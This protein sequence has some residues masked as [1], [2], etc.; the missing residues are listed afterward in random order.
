VRTLA[1]RS[2]QAA[3]EIKQLIS[4]SV[5][6]VES[7]S[8]LVREAGVTMDDI[9][10]SVQRVSQVIGEITAATSEQS[11]GLG[12]INQAVVQLDRMTQQNAALVEQSSAAAESMK[13]QADGLR[14]GVQ[15]FRLG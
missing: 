1:Q 6:Q 15:V 11:E 12:Q 4:R 9:V 8:V 2:A 3:K 10:N 14:E 13:A 7:G 5:E